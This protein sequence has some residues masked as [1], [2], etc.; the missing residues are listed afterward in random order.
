M[1]EP[2]F[3]LDSN[4]CIY[5]LRGMSELLFAHMAAQPAG[6]L[7]VSVISLSEISVGYGAAVFN[8]PELAGFLDV[9]I[10]MPFDIEAA[11]IYGTL[12]FKRA[13][14][15]RL[16]AAHALALDMTLITNNE[17][18]FADIPGLRTEN[19]TLPQ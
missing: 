1:P 6:S 9:V 14:F 12:P 5:A 8:S 10:P 17:A 4:I 18:D 19:W 3:L 16:V 11:M 15:D 2:A 7:A 13:K